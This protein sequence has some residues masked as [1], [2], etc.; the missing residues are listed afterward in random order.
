MEADPQVRREWRPTLRS[1]ANVGR[2]FRSGAMEESEMYRLS[3]TQQGIVDGAAAVADADL[4]PRA[5]AVDRDGTFPKDGIA[6]LGARGLLGLNVSKEHGGLGEGLRTAAAA[7][8]QIARRCPS[9]AMVYLM[10]LCGVACYAAVPDKTSPLLRA[11]A[12]GRHLSTLAFSEK[13]SRSHFWAPVSRASANGSDGAV[14]ISAQKSFVTS[15]GHADGYVV[16]TLASRGTQP[17]E[18]TI[19]LVLKE[20]AGVSVSGP[21]RGLGLRGNASAPM[22]LDN[23]PV[24]SDRALTADGKGLDMMLGIVLPLFQVGSA[25]VGIGIAE[26]AVQAAIAHVTHARFEEANSSLRDLP[27]V[28]AQ[29]AKMRIET[30]RARAHLA[31]VLDSLDN[32]GPA[33]QLMVLEAKA[34]GTEAA[35]AVTELAMR[36]CGGAAFGGAH[37]IERLFRDAR[38]P[39]V[40]SPTS[41]LAYEFIGRAL[42]GLEVF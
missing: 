17:L 18:S 4:A 21:W 19:Y 5:A 36:T 23:V 38:A 7:I 11:A 22:T 16:S 39:I 37:G 34:S 13:G 3:E 27:T 10:H 31:A 2:T 29:I 35:V 42:C 32:P 6:A 28:R 41:D 15:A 1:G 40:M 33:T 24:G 26:A 9:T 12:A 8:D 14:Q 25:A 30:D 20:D